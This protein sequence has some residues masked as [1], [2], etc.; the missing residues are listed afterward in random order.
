MITH[1]YNTTSVQFGLD[2]IG[3]VGLLGYSK[4]D[5]LTGHLSVQQ[6][7]TEKVIGEKWEKGDVHELPKVVF[8][9]TDIG[10][11]ET[12][13]KVLEGVRRNMDRNQQMYSLA[14]AC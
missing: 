14:S 3:A 5:G 12:L 6:L 2:K 9:F 4:F 1:E 11:V 8:N 13:I 7:A 10:S